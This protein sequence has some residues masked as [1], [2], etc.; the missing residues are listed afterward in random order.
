MRKIHFGQDFEQQLAFCV[1]ARSSFCNLEP[2]LVFLVQ[3]VNRLAISTRQVVKGNHTRKTSA[4]IRACLAYSFITIPSIPGVFIR[5]QLYLI[6]AQV[7]IINQALTQG[8]AFLKAAISLVAEVPRLIDD[9]GKSRATE[10]LLINYI[11]HFLSSLLVVPDHPDHGVVYILKGLMNALQEYSWDN[12][13]AKVRLYLDVLVL[14]SALSQE[15]YL[16][17]IDH[18]IVVHTCG[19][20]CYNQ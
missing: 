20:L 14:L 8:D 18:G 19:Y 10:P 13:D 11:K 17:N 1:E 16:H 3:M 7:A 4:F 12:G 6:S 9:D 15:A 5:L 2:V